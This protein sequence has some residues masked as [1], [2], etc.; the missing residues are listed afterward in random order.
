MS[1]RRAPVGNEH[2][3]GEHGYR[4]GYHQW[5]V[6]DRHEQ[7]HGS[8]H[9]SQVRPDVE[10]V[11][12]DDQGDRSVEHH[13]REPTADESGEALAGHESQARCDLLHG[14][15]QRETY[16]GRPQ[17]AESKRRPYLR[18]GPDAGW[19]VVRRSGNEARPE[20]SEVAESSKSLPAWVMAQGLDHPGSLGWSTRARRHSRGWLAESVALLDWGPSRLIDLR[21]A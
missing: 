12:S 6:G 21:Q 17:Q 3:E 13:A 19:I 20:A 5:D 15:S 8:G 11:R 1:Q 9:G 7:S 18:V 2:L 16:D 10:H 14:R 4:D